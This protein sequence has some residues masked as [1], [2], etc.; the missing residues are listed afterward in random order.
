MMGWGSIG[1]HIVNSTAGVW[2]RVQAARNGRIFNVRLACVEFAL[3]GFRRRFGGLSS[4]SD[5]KR[6]FVNLT[7]L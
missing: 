5:L 6:L 2:C 7:I 4:S 1:I 3:S